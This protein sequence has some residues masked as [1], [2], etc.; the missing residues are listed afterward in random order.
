MR[1]I[2]SVLASVAL[3]FAPV[4]L[5]LQAATLNYNNPNQTNSPYKVT[6]SQILN[7]QIL[8]Q[9]VGCTGI[10]NKV[11]DT[12]NAGLKKAETAALNEATK[13]I[14]QTAIAQ[15]LAAAKEKAK[16]KA[17]KATAT[18]LASSNSYIDATYLGTGLGDYITPL[19]TINED[20]ISKAQTIKV[21]DQ[22]AQKKL[23]DAAKAKIKA[24]AAAAQQ[25]NL[26][27]FRSG[28][29]DG[30]AIQLA[31][32]QLTAMTRDTMN[33]VTSGFNGTPFYPRNIDSFMN[34]LTS[35]LLM[36]ETDYFEN[37][38]NAH[39]GD[40]PWGR[41]YARSQINSFR[42]LNDQA[43]PYQALKTD[44]F[45]YLIPGATVDTYSTNFSQGGWDGWLGL[46]QHLADNPLGFTMQAANNL[47]QRQA[48]AINDTQQTLL[49]SGGY[50]NQQKCDEWS[51][52]VNNGFT[53]TTPTC[54][55]YETVTPGSA[56][57]DKI[58]T[59]I[60]SPERQIELVK[61]M[62][63]AL[64]ALFA[65][66]LG[67]FQNQGLTGLGTNT[68]DFSSAGTGFGSNELFDSEG[69]IIPVGGGENTAGSGSDGAFDI[70]KDLGNTYTQAIN[71][72]SW[73][74][75]ANNPQLLPGV[76]SKYHYYT[77]S[78]SGSTDITGGNDYWNKGD[79][80]YFNGTSWSHGLPTH[81]INKK[82]VLQNEQDFID[83]TKK[84]QS[85]ITNIMPALGQLDYC[86]PGPN[87]SWQDSA[88]TAEQDVINNQTVDEETDYW[89]GV[90]GDLMSEYS[91]R[92]DTLYGPSSPMQTETLPS[93]NPNPSYLK[94]SPAGL[95]LTT[96]IPTY[97]G[98]VDQA[99][100]DSQVALAQA[101]SDIA[102]LN[103]IK[104]KVNQIIAAAQKR[105]DTQR[106]KDGLPAFKQVCLDAEKVTYVANGVLK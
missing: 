53:T 17:L 85:V 69:N 98:T 67:R 40:F 87:P 60:N 22:T 32:N 47:A 63:D 9:V 49:Q 45:N 68:V 72:G 3:L 103:T 88:T 33:W 95:A 100:T 74:A 31:K 11:A 43:N 23:D 73:D 80:A 106:K 20:S 25:A 71:S 7:P 52:P 83:S 93:G 38:D 39:A 70:T 30:I 78:I 66:L 29:I 37:L 16:A 61:T 76:G 59:Y 51:T 82:G 41:D 42:S 104:D 91:Q 1:I 36:K 26:E 58:N 24:D 18:A 79:V 62:N 77:V 34:S 56:I 4:A 55:K 86:I 97:A 46:T 12:V 28:C 19:I 96:D 27:S 99:K 57:R 90:A 5:P 2:V 64:N 92:I 50:F 6:V 75:N 15:K 13:L 10:V 44:I 54:L 35:G 81:I 14:N 21:T 84:Y 101:N 8:T 89:T 94:M 48:Q 65:S 102:K 105:R